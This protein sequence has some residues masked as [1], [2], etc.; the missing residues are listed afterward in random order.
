QVAAGSLDAC[1][2]IY[3]ARVDTV[4]ADTYK[5]LGGLGRD[6]A[7]AKGLDSPGEGG[8]FPHFP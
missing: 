1:A 3:S 6:S 5:V 8:Q 7:P 2:K 4:H